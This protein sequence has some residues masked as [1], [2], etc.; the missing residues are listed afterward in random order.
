M[1]FIKLIQHYIALQGTFQHLNN[2]NTEVH[3]NTYMFKRSRDIKKNKQIISK[4]LINK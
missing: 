1:N 3:I 2:V 4:Q